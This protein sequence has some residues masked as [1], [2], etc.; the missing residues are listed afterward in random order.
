MICNFDLLR[1]F[2][3]YFAIFN[4]TFGYTHTFFPQDLGLAY[5]QEE[6]RRKKKKVTFFNLC[7]I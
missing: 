2:V 7:V 5:N 6:K 4:A 1:L 3:P